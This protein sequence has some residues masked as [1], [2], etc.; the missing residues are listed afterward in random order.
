MKQRSRR[1]YSLQ[2]M[3]EA[4]KGKPREQ[5]EKAIR[6]AYP[7][8]PRQYWPYK[9]WLQARKEFLGRVKPEALPE[10]TAIEGQGKMFEEEEDKP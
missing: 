9:A 10:P 8:G 5:W 2:V 7:F 1:E 4:V 3:A 6:E